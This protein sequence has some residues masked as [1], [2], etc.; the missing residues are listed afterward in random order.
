MVKR[1]KI[2]LS[3]CFC[4]IALVILRRI[5]F[6][7][8]SG[9]NLLDLLAAVFRCFSVSQRSDLVLTSSEFA[10][11]I[12]W[13]CVR[14]CVVRVSSTPL[15]NARSRS[16]CMNGYIGLLAPMRIDLFGWTS[17]DRGFRIWLNSCD[18]ATGPE[19]NLSTDASICRL[20]AVVLKIWSSFTR[21]IR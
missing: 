5:C 4:W 1:L 2:F 11:S 21:D 19:W 18:V 15:F 12:A 20:D 10:I 13:V 7:S 17:S 16:M 14:D 3:G 6:R 9:C 8:E